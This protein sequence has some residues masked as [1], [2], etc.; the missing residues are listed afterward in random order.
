MILSLWAV[1]EQ[2]PV[3]LLFASIVGAGGVMAYNHRPNKNSESQTAIDGLT[4][5]VNAHQ[6]EMIRLNKR[7]S[8]LSA[9]V[10]LL[11]NELRKANLPVP[12]DP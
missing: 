8:V 3:W 9:R 1:A 6:A 10:F 12:S 7:V 5:L 2:N 4:A 11:E